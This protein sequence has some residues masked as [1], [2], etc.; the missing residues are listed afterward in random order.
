MNLGDTTKLAV[1]LLVKAIEAR[2]EKP[3][4]KIAVVP[5]A[6]KKLKMLTDV[7]IGVH[8][9]SIEGSGAQ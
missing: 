8:Q 6:T 9:R 3:R 4:I 2:G 5:A 1:K 7:E